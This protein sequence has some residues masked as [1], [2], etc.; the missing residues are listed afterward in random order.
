MFVLQL[1]NEVVYGNGVKKV[2]HP[3]LKSSSSMRKVKL[4]PCGPLVLV[5]SSWVHC[6]NT[7]EQL[8]SPHSV[9]TIWSHS[10]QAENISRVSNNQ[11]TCFG[12]KAS[13]GKMSDGWTR[14]VV[15]TIFSLH[16]TCPAF[17]FHVRFLCGRP[18]ASSL[19]AH[20][21]PVCPAWF[22]VVSAECA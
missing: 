9:V 5:T 16:F 10:I 13:L 14:R 17:I 1:F 8:L 15:Q 20:S 11:L 19:F 22:N 3:L 18:C 6:V 7:V 4:A 2:P 21:L 12:E